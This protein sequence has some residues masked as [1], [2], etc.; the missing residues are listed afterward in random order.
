MRKVG[1]KPIKYLDA[2]KWLMWNNLQNRYRPTTGNRKVARRTIAFLTS[3]EKNRNRVRRSPEQII[4][5][6]WG[7]QSYIIP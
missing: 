6:A 5:G 1:R 7:A 3:L 4:R 2:I